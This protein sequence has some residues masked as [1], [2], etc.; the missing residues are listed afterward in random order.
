MNFQ[1]GMLCT[2]NSSEGAFDVEG[3]FGFTDSSILGPR[4]SNAEAFLGDPRLGVDTLPLPRPRPP[5]I[6]PRD[7]DFPLCLYPD[8]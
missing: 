4:R 2:Y 8:D 7:G 6:E 3:R 1:S 5:L